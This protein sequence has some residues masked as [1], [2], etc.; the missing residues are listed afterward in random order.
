[1]GNLWILSRR[2]S[3]KGI[4]TTVELGWVLKQPFHKIPQTWGPVKCVFRMPK[5]QGAPGRTGEGEVDRG[6]G[7]GNMI[8]WVEMGGEERG[9]VFEGGMIAD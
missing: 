8:V 2:R 1:M 5:K 6:K 7:G 4:E 9:R 3:W